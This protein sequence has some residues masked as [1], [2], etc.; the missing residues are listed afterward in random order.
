MTGIDLSCRM[1]E[2]AE[3]AE[4]ADPQ[5]VEYRVGS[6]SDHCGLPDTSFDAVVSTLALMDGPNLSGAM[7]EAFRILR[8]GGFI[9]FSVL[10]PVSSRQATA[11][12]RM[13]RANDRASRGTLL[14]SNVLHRALA[15]RSSSKRPRCR[16]V[17]SSPV[18]TDA[19]RLS[20]RRSFCRLH[21]DGSRG[22][23][24]INSDLR[25]LSEFRTLEGSRGTPLSRDRNATGHVAC[26]Q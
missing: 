14:R 25:V 6:Y 19:R 12:K 18:P 24:T 16:R 2:Q 11:G 4:K 3:L 7:Q 17:R 20:E 9:H 13:R 23:A 22:A 1:I 21:L 15:L 8:P 10:P 5:G 26:S